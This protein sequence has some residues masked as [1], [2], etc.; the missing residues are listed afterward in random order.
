MASAP[1]LAAPYGRN[2]ELGPSNN[3]GFAPS[4]PA[5]NKNVELGPAPK[6]PIGLLG[7]KVASRRHL[8]RNL[9]GSPGG[10]TKK[11]GGKRRTMQKRKRAKK[12]NKRRH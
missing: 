9:S 4:L 6:S 12:T 2:I 3:R 7:T 8:L 10:N 1:T 11:F 5:L